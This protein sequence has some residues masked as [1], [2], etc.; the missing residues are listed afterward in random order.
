MTTSDPEKSK[1]VIPNVCYVRGR[2]HRLCF[3]I[4]NSLLHP[5]MNL[6]LISLLFSYYIARSIVGRLD[7]VLS[8]DPKTG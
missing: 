8:G 4:K 2:K 3:S 6:A 7:C 1:G 5:G